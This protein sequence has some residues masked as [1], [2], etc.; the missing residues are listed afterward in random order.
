M[1]ATT[2]LN[3]IIEK[4]N[5]STDEARSLLEGIMDGALGPVQGGAI[6]TALRMKGESEEEILAFIETMRSKMLTIRAPGAIDIVGT[7]GGS[8]DPFNVST[9]AA[10]VARGAGAKVA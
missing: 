10:F 8:F 7:G 3:K 2:V 9:A 6:L 1:D 5:L 4:K